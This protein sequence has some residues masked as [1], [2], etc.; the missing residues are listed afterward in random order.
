L[1][2]TIKQSLGI[3]RCCF[4]QQKW[5][6]KKRE[7]LKIITI[8]NPNMLISPFHRTHE[9]LI[10]PPRFSIKKEKKTVA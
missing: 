5:I 1:Y 9:L 2:N 3:N 10:S 6:K 8:K 4:E 7:E